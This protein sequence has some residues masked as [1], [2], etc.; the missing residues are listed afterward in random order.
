MPRA[1]AAIL[2]RQ[3]SLVQKIDRPTEAISVSAWFAESPILISHRARSRRHFSKRVTVHLFLARLLL[4]QL[5]SRQ[6]SQ[7]VVHQRQE[8]QRL[9][10]A[11]ATGRQ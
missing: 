2:L 7:L 9:R 10:K 8:L 1:L 11:E 3:H 6:L 4:S 5:Q